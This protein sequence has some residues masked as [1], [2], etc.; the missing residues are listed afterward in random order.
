MFK[1]EVQ[2]SGIEKVLE[3]NYNLINKTVFLPAV[4]EA[5]KIISSRYKEILR[6]HDKADRKPGNTGVRA[7][8]AVGTKTGV[9]SLGYGAWAVVGGKTSNGQ[10]LAPQQRFGEHGTKD[11]FTKRGQRRGIMPPQR[12]LEQAKADTLA[13]AQKVLEERIKFLVARIRT[14]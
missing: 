13:A 10:M 8:M 6:M 2:V 9:F 1:I 7:F 3:V 14:N 12:W 4:K 11:R 5:A